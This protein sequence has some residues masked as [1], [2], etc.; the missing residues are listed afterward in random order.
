MDGFFLLWQMGSNSSGNMVVGV[1]THVDLY[2]LAR[3]VL[4]QAFSELACA[5][6]LHKRKQFTNRHAK[7]CLRI[8]VDS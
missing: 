4:P 7:H 5:K 2:R 8:L 6:T 3:D 1:G